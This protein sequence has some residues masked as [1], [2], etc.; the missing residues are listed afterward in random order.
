MFVIQRQTIYNLGSWGVE[1][2][3]APLT[4]NI[5]E[6][7]MAINHNKPT[8]KTF[9][10]LTGKTFGRLQVISFAGVINKNSQWNC[11][12]LCGKEVVKAGGSM[13]RG[14]T[15]SCGC[16]KQEM[17]VQKKTT[18]GETAKGQLTPEFNT[19]AKLRRRCNNPKD[20]AYKLYGGRGIKVCDRWDNSFENFLIDM[21][22]KPSPKHSIDRIN[23]N[24]H[25]EPNN[26]R[27]ATLKEQSRNKRTNIWLTHNEETLLI[28]DWAAKVK[29]K[30]D[31][32]RHRYRVGWTPEEILSTPLNYRK[33][34]KKGN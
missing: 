6:V 27:W 4:K 2:P 30:A 16:L 19:W 25:Y 18:H 9:Q 33:N 24:G 7:C 5:L 1:A 32:L 26:C 10:D 12:C 34:N 31:V 28:E 11:I 15:L 20:K 29:I 14:S 23:N 17:L 22:R 13:Y 21:G 8:R 3:P